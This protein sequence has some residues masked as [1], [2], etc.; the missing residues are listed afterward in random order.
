MNEQNNVEANTLPLIFRTKIIAFATKSP[1]R[2]VVSAVGET[3]FTLTTPFSLSFFFFIV[4]D[5][6]GEMRS[7]DKSLGIKTFSLSSFVR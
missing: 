6:N 5:N 4:K 2:L 1:F 3:T 7:H